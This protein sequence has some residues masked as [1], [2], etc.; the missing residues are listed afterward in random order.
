MGGHSGKPVG[1]GGGEG[2]SVTN[3]RNRL[4]SPAKFHSRANEHNAIFRFQYMDRVN[5]LFLIPKI[6]PNFPNLIFLPFSFE[7]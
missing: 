1:G 5:V 7:G 3:F 4:I 6:M 2:A